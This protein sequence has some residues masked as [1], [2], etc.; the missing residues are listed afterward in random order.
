MPNTAMLDSIVRSSSRTLAPVLCVIAGLL[1]V[2]FG[3]M[4]LRTLGDVLDA[5]DQAAQEQAWSQPP[6]GGWSTDTMYVPELLSEEKPAVYVRHVT[7]HAG[8]EE[9]ESGVVRPSKIM[10]RPDDVVRFTTDGRADHNIIFAPEDN[11]GVRGLPWATPYLS[12]RRDA[13]DVRINLEPGVY[14]FRCA[15]HG[16]LGERGVLEV[17]D[18]HTPI[19]DLANIP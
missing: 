6:P 4:G 16:Y 15:I 8:D 2:S 12:G 19:P 5:R 13:F 10:V 9:R 3:S 7:R 11:P 14:H 17:V 18:D 1:T